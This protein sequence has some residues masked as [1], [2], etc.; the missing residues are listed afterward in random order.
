MKYPD[1]PI[2]SVS[3]L[4]EKL[5]AH[6]DIYAGPVWFRGQTNQLWNL[7]PKLL[8]GGNQIP[9][10]HY[11]TRFK[12]DASLIINHQP[13][14]EFDWLF[15]M[16]HYGVPTRLLD[17]SESPLVSLYFA[18][19]ELAEDGCLWV[20][21]PTELNKISRYRSV[22]DFEIP[23]FED[24]Q[25]APYIPSTIAAESKT[26]LDPMA[27]IA[28]RNSQRMQAQKGVFTISHRENTFINNL[29][30]GGSADHIWRYV[31]PSASK[32][33]ILRELKLLGYNKFQ[34]FPEL[35]SLAANLL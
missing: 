7:E 8:R 17:W 19:T 4:I 35:E 28:P 24:P 29:R 34:L 23:S 5:Q 21:L 25:L 33:N 12:Q 30:L 31:I 20:L 16:Q 2:H 14:S 3:E 15:L 26:S 10:T 32:D 13:K 18:T 27:A 6:I 9:E 11:F 22:Y 1:E